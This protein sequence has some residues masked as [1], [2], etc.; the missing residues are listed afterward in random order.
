MK[1]LRLRVPNTLECIYQIEHI[2]VY[3]PDWTYPSTTRL[4]TFEYIYQ[5]EHIRVLPDW[6]HS[7]TSARFVSEYYQMEHIRVHLTDWTYSS[8]STRLNISNRLDHSVGNRLN[9]RSAIAVRDLNHRNIPSS[10]HE[11]VAH[12]YIGGRNEKK[13]IHVWTQLDKPSLV[14]LIKSHAFQFNSI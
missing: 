6:T 4:N 11:T 1:D 5:I 14:F 3:L 2:R 9:T 13:A 10:H 7:S 8:I 12:K